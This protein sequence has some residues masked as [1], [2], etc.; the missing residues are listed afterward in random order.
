MPMTTIHLIYACF[1]DVQ[2]ALHR[3]LIFLM[4]LKLRKSGVDASPFNAIV[5]LVTN[6]TKCVKPE[7]Y[8]ICHSGSLYRKEPDR[9]NV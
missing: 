4:L 6:S 8:G 9:V 7:G 1:L 5:T 2:R 3:T